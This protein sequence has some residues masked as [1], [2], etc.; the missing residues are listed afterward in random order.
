MIMLSPV[1]GIVR[2]T[3]SFL[4]SPGAVLFFGEAPFRLFGFR[5]EGQATALAD[6]KSA[7]VVRLDDVGDVVLTTP[8]LRELRRNLPGAWIT[9]AVRP[10]TQNLVALCPY[11]DEILAYDWD[12]RG[13]LSQVERH[14]RALS[15]SRRHLWR[16]R[17][18]IA[19]IPRWGVDYYHAAFVA[20]LSG[21]RQRVGYS[22][23]ASAEKE[24][25]NRGFD[26][27]LTH[28][29]EWRARNHEVEHNLEVIR[30][31]GGVVRDDRPELWLSGD[32]ESFAERLLASDNVGAGEYL[33][34]LGPGAGSPKRMWPIDRFV[35]LAEWVT[36]EYGARV[37]IIRSDREAELGRRVR[38]R[39]GGKVIDAGGTTLRQA[40][41]LLKRCHLFIGNDSGPMHLAAA[42]GVPVIEISCHPQDG[43]PL[44]PNSPSIFGPW[45]RP[46][47]V[48]QPETGLKPC[49]ERC[50][51]AEPHCILAIQVDEVMTAV[52]SLLNRRRHAS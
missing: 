18:D 27:L 14:R 33:V 34:A 21:A 19:I 51:A 12:T 32:D 7:L 38:E 42:A 50:D 3:L 25:V 36:R 11:V 23:T 39:L 40:A 6:A 2:K 29:L 15:L 31:L 37:I 20:Y 46:S 48:L 9:L 47:R 43:S 41:A 10:A 16:R 22:E 8:F 13:R 45:A 17:F 35:E 28:P 52:P 26:R 4:C 30:R 24:E 49:S 5:R 1:R 44:H